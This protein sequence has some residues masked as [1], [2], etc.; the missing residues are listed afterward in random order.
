VST[1]NKHCATLL[2]AWPIRSARP[3]L[4]TDRSEIGAPR[5]GRPDELLICEVWVHKAGADLCST[6]VL[7]SVG[8]ARKLD[9]D[10][11][12]GHVIDYS[13]PMPAGI[14][15]GAPVPSRSGALVE[16]A[17]DRLVALLQH[18]DGV[19]LTGMPANHKIIGTTLGRPSILWCLEGGHHRSALW[20]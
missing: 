4:V 1:P 20:V 5:V 16:A 10:V 13:E 3:R 11:R 17:D 18:I 6:I 9:R 15:T 7:K 2:A 19:P 12:L 8:A 14:T